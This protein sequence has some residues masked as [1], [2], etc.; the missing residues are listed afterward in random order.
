M[1]DKWIFE[2][3]SSEYSTFATNIWQEHFQFCELL[4]IMRQNDDKNFAQLLNH[5]REGNHTTENINSLKTRI[6]SKG[7]SSA[8]HISGFTHLFLT[9]AMVNSFNNSVFQSLSRDKAIV[10][11]IDLVI[12][13]LKD[14]VKEKLMKRIPNDQTKTMGLHSNLPI[15]VG[16]KYDLTSNI[17]IEDGLTNGAE[18]IVMKIDYRVSSSNRPSIIWVSFTEERIGFLQRSEYR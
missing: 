18:C 4:T 15:V 12:G 2:G 7:M 9:N 14:D 5:L 13:D 6:I 10:K 1:F 11:A 8:A 17:K 16:E 3:S